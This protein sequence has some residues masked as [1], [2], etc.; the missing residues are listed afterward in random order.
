MSAGRSH[1]DTS[2]NRVGDQAHHIFGGSNESVTMT[3]L[4]KREKRLHAD[5]TLRDAAFFREREKE[6]ALALEKTHRLRELR[7]AKEALERD[8]ADKAVQ[9]KRKA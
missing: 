1:D 6:R 8:A 4:G 2:K 9:S 3:K 7:L 5:S